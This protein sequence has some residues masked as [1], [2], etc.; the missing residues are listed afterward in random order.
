[1][2]N[3]KF[4]KGE[5]VSSYANVECGNLLIADCEQEGVDAFECNANANLIAAAPEMY[6]MLKKIHDSMAGISEYGYF[7][8]DVK[9]M[10]AK[11]R[12]E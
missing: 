10:L 12:G 7:Y 1:M 11:A 2:S 5:W 8:Y 4:T 9:D 6:A 3:E